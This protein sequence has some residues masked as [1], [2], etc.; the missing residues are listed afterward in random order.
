MSNFTIEQ[1]DSA[2]E[3]RILC[4][5][6]TNEQFLREVKHAVD[7]GY[8]KSQYH[9]SIARAAIKHFEQFNNPINENIRDSIRL[10][11]PNDSDNYREA[12]EQLLQRITTAPKENTPYLVTEAI[13]FF[14]K[15]EL[16]ITTNNITYFL[17]QGKVE[18]AEKA[19]NDYVKIEPKFS[20]IN[21]LFDED[22]LL[23][24]FAAKSNEFFKI[25]GDLGRFLGNME[26]GWLVGIMGAFKR[27]KT[28]LA[29]EFGII[30]MLSNL[31]V[32]FFSL[33]M[34]KDRMYER[35]F[36]RLSVSSS[37]KNHMNPVFDCKKNQTD[38][39]QFARR[40]NNIALD[41]Q[42]GEPVDFAKNRQYRICTFCKDHAAYIQNFETATWFEKVET[43]IYDQLVAAKAKDSLNVF[44]KGRFKFKA[45]P[46]YTASIEDIKADL[47]IL[48]VAH[49]WVPD[50]IIVD[51]ADIL[52]PEP[53]SPTE[54][55]EKEDRSW[56]ALAQLA[57]EKKALVIAPTQVTKEG[58]DAH[59]L[60]TK[61][62]ARWIGKL[63]HIDAMITINQTESEKRCGVMRI[64]V[65]E[66]RHA[67]FYE[68]DS[69]TVLQNLKTAQ[70]HLDSVKTQSHNEGGE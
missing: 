68:T 40:T 53:G 24:H 3:S 38:E 15:R 48:E 64:G 27:G 37:Q 51:Y 1:I 17:E 52:K 16:E 5:L 62:N 23:S 50:I 19:L 36:K 69:C 47:N 49:G 46:R 33:E 32:A 41:W 39:C 45:Y 70:V 43:P 4:A 22:L 25:P 55:T 44:F 28:W 56:I 18:E 11:T 31:N 63:G 61:H 54:G 42:H 12:I 60:G 14:K 66:H 21:D 65:M 6:L 30:G 13:K 29:M 58:L 57:G 9:Q 8:F 35:I 59:H 34:T 67:E 2:L 26:R 10:A 7:I 20:D